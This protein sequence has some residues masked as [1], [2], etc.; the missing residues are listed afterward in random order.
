MRHDRFVRKVERQIEGERESAKAASSLEAASSLAASAVVA[1]LAPAPASV[2][3]GPPFPGPRTVAARPH[4]LLRLPPGAPREVGAREASAR[5]ARQVG[6]GV[7]GGRPAGGRTD[8]EVAWLGH[9]SP[10]RGRLAPAG[11]VLRELTPIP[12]HLRDW[13]RNIVFIAGRCKRLQ[14]PVLV[15]CAGDRQRELSPL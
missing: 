2:P 13:H 5:A 12:F 11:L 3:T 4:P 7:S 1:V 9:P 10:G 14:A 15:H 6:A 8:A